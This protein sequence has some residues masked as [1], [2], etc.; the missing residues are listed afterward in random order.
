M[1]YYRNEYI[2]RQIFPLVKT[3]IPP[4]RH[5]PLALVRAGAARPPA[6]VLPAAPQQ[7]DVLWLCASERLYRLAVV[8][9]GVSSYHEQRSTPNNSFQY[10]VSSSLA[11]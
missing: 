10:Q 1:V 4:D 3:I 8:E 7:P 11:R 6:T 2:G 5:P 9:G